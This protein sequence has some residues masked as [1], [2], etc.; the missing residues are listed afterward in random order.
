MI[1]K[2]E[3]K[4]AIKRQLLY[5]R[6]QNEDLVQKQL[7]MQQLLGKERGRCADLEA[8]LEELRKTNEDRMRAELQAAETKFA[9]M[10]EVLTPRYPHIKE[11]MKEFGLKGGEADTGG[12]IELLSE[13]LR[14]LKNG[15]R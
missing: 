15:K 2:L 12:L 10:A 3:R 14:G 4:R 5:V 1:A 8:R 6:K 9:S 7:E 13:A 11:R